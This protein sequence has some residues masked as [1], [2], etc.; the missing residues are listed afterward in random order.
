MNQTAQDAPGV[1]GRTKS[2]R[3]PISRGTTR[4]LPERARQIG[5]SSSIGQTHSSLPLE[6]EDRLRLDRVVTHMQADVSSSRQCPQR[7][8]LCSNKVWQLLRLHSLD[9][10]AVLA[11]H[12][13]LVS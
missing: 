10:S 6:F 11:V 9:E 3:A 1:L 13:V 7:I 5:P 12:E 8:I 4:C 2:D